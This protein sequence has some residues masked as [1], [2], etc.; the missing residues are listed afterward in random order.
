MKRVLDPFITIV[1]LELVMGDTW[2]LMLFTYLTVLRSEC[3][4]PSRTDVP[5]ARLEDIINI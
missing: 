2:N 3:K 5:P 4:V 1:S